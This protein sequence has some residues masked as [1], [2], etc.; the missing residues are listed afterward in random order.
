MTQYK[1]YNSF[2]RLGPTRWAPTS[3]KWPYKKVTWFITPISGVISLLGTGRGPLC[4]N[5]LP[6]QPL[7]TIKSF[8]FFQ[9][10]APYKSLLLWSY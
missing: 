7:T 4:V 5:D 8:T 3:Y 6:K 10:K 9:S 2:D 1:G